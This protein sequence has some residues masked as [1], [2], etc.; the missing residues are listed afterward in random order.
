MVLVGSR[1]KR[2]LLSAAI[3]LSVPAT[4]HS[5]WPQWRGTRRDGSVSASATK[6][7]WPAQPVLVWE[8]EVGEGYSGPVV[9]G[10]RVWVHARKGD[11]EVVSSLT[12]TAGELVWSGRYEAPFEQDDSARGHG[13][14]PYS[15]PSLADGRLF[16]LGVTAVLSAWDAESGKLLWRRASSEE[17]EPSFPYFGAAASP[18]VWGDMCFVHFGGHDRGNAEDPGPGAMIAWRV[19]DG[20][21]L[22][23]W[24]GDGPALAA[25]PVIH[26]I[27]GRRQLVFKTQKKIVG[28]DPRTGKELWR[29]P[30]KVDMDNTIVTPLLI[31]DRLLTSDW[32]MGMRAWRIHLT[33]ESWTVRELW[34]NSKVSLFM[35]SPVVVKS[36]IVGF[37]HFRKGQLFGLDPNNGDVLW[38]EEPKWGEH[39]S[40][41]RWGD[42]VLVFLEDGLLIVGEVS[43]DRFKAVRRYRLASSR[44][45]GH[46][47]LVDGRIIIR[48]GSRL[49]V[50]RVGE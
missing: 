33:G 17:F 47:A 43:R 37:S 26:E 8:R 25:S 1:A 13:R 48:D 20:E 10:D 35:S 41:I 23:R 38:R 39:A 36:Q 12:L 32:E 29:I 34:K 24:H 14:G 18:L 19:A 3:L 2:S 6:A 22:W 4:V 30:F 40:L 9:A 44:T 27:E 15:T 7:D 42:K 31:G 11:K 21:Q 50:Y 5:E 49:A 16:T 28:L 46:P 45:W